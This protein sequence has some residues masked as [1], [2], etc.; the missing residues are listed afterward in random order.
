METTKQSGSKWLS[1][2]QKEKSEKPA[3]KLTFAPLINEPETPKNQEEE[4]SKW[5]MALHKETTQKGKKDARNDPTRAAR[6][7][8]LAHLF[9][10]SDEE[11]EQEDTGD[12]QD[13]RMD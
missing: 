2:I 13:D 10:D 4:T 12:K 9:E 6:M 3:Q 11:A 8:R 5:L 7:A 1:I